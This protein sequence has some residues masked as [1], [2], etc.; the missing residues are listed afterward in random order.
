MRKVFWGAVGIGLL[1]VAFWGGGLALFAVGAGPGD[2]Q[3]VVI[4]VTRGQSP[5]EVARILAEKQIIADAEDFRRLGRLTGSWGK[6]K[7]GEYQ[8]S[9]RMSPLQI[10]EVLQ[11][12]ISVGQPLTVR[13]G[14]N[15]YEIAKK[16]E[17]LRPGSGAE[18][19]RL[20]KDPVLIAAL[21]PG[22]HS[23]EGYLFPDTYSISRNMPVAEI[24]RVMTKHF[25]NIWEPTWT[26]R[27]RVL[28]LSRHQVMT[29]ASIIEKETGAAHERP[30]ISS[31]IHNRLKKRM[32]LQMDSTTIYGMWTRYD[33]NIRRSDLLTPS[34]YNTYTVAALPVGPIGNPGKE[35]I[36]AALFPAETTYLYFVSHNDGT[37][38]FT[39]TLAEHN[40]AVRKYQIDPAARKGKSWRDLTKR[41]TSATSSSQ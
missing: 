41:P 10:F 22:A 5:R 6:L 15:S 13:E 39:S 4:E 20:V 36:Q 18:F 29:L 9:S 38:E 37:Q 31:V 30:L 27:A 40:A 32:R 24:V 28:G 8:V 2:G 7:A 26:E 3:P 12:G 25:E 21:D 17:Q 23:L 35:S 16:L 19:L 1:G 33:G 11:S 34:P 14:E